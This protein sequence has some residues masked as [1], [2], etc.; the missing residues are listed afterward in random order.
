[1]DV[2]ILV[3]SSNVSQY[4]NKLTFVP[5]TLWSH[6]L[7]LDPLGDTKLSLPDSI[8]PNASLE[9]N[10]EA[11]FTNTENERHTKTLTLSYDA[12]AYGVEYELVSDSLHFREKS[13]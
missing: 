9:Y 3:K 10:V 7:K 11:T 8:F 1:I 4:Y 6:H 12:R 5:D 13:S 2:T